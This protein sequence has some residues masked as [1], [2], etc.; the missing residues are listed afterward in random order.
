MITSVANT[1]KEISENNRGENTMMNAEEFTARFAKADFKNALF[2]RALRLINDKIKNFKFE[3][4]LMSNATLLGYDTEY[5]QEGYVENIYTLGIQ[6]CNFSNHAG[7]LDEE[8]TCTLLRNFGD[9]NSWWNIIF[10]QKL[11]STITDFLKGNGYGLKVILTV[12]K[13]TYADEDFEEKA[14]DIAKSITEKC[15]KIRFEVYLTV[16][17][18]GYNKP[19][20]QYFD[21]IDELESYS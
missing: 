16:K 20:E 10:N 17:I 18:K 1:N 11:Y 6:L 21:C 7:Q 13:E 15:V 2:N 19:M 3:D 12:G 5:L 4:P 14:D 9:Y 8:T